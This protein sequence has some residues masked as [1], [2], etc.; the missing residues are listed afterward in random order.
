MLNSAPESEE[1]VAY[2]EL[3]Q[4]GMKQLA[5]EFLMDFKD[6]LNSI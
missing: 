3:V 5:N 6:L 1:K 2:D 4:R